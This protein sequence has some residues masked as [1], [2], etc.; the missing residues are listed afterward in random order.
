[1]YAGDHVISTHHI[2]VLLIDA[3]T[4]YFMFIVVL[5]VTRDDEKVSV[6]RWFSTMSTR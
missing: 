2:S 6:D 3:V 1:M 5:E 4:Q